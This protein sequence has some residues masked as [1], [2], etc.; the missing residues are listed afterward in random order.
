MI[1]KLQSHFKISMVAAST[2]PAA[3]SGGR[4]SPPLLGGGGGPPCVLAGR[5]WGPTYIAAYTQHTEPWVDFLV[6]QLLI[7][8][9]NQQILFAG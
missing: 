4:S 3:I 5:R 9:E 2:G 7:W 1:Y 6:L 8:W